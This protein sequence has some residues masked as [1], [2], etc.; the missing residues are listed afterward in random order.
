MK[1]K[2]NINYCMKKLK[3]LSETLS[4]INKILKKQLKTKLLRTFNDFM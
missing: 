3:K 2:F 1:E 4:K